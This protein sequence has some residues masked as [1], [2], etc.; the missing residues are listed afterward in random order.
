MTTKTAVSPAPTLA[1]TGAPGWTI[2]LMASACGLIAANL[3][4]AQPLIKLIAPDIG[5]HLSAASLIV[6]LTQ[7]GYCAGLVLLV[8]LGDLVENR[9]LVLWTLG[10]A[11]VALA[12]AACSASAPWFLG[13]SLAIG[14]GS[15]AVQMLV[16]MAAHLAPDASRGQVVGKVMSGLLTGIMLSR[17]VASLVASAFGWRAV[18]GGSAA[19]MLVLGAVLRR[20]LPPRRPASGQGYAALIA[21]LWT[22]L[23]QHPVLRRRAAYQAALFAGFSLYWTAVPLVLSSPAFGLSQRGIAWFTLAG[24]AG[25]LSAPVAGRLADRGRTRVATGAALAMVAASFALAW[26][27]AAGSLAALLA[28]GILLDLG[29]QANLVLGQRAIYALGEHVRSRLNGLYMAIFFAGGAIGSSVASMAYAHGGWALVSG[30]GLA[31]P[32][33]ALVFYATEPAP[34]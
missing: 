20:A 9:D 11:L 22:L 14:I 32:L 25:A 27:G 19:L 29:V 4:Y 1:Q 17:P 2:F 24:V 6:T 12:V 34:G 5:L 3:Y 23:R 16:P 21:S 31:F 26:V 15:V 8:P 13:A 33:V 28:A 18:F 30:I 10:G 7:I